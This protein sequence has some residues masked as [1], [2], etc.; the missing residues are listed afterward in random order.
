MVHCRVFYKKYLYRSSIIP[1]AS[2]CTET[3][4]ISNIFR[5]YSFVPDGE[6]VAT[7]PVKVSPRI[8]QFLIS[9][10]L[11]FLYYEISSFTKLGEYKN[12]LGFRLIKM[13]IEQHD[14]IAKMPSASII[15]QNVSI[16][17]Y[18]CMA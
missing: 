1:F 6:K 16:T 5:I 3:L 15:T 17:I 13:S 8:W 11:E 14:E 12:E 10:K 4:V 2:P 7:I 9:K 18:T